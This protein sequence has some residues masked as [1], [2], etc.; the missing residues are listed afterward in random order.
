MPT[1]VYEAL[2]SVGQ[3]VKGTVDATSRDE[4]QN[5]IRAQGHYPTKLKE[6]AGAKA[7][8]RKQAGGGQSAGPRRRSVG[9]IP[10]KLLTQFTRQLSTLVDAG[11]PIVRSLDILEEQQKP[12]TMRVAIRLVKEDVTEGS[13]LSDAMK[14]HPRAFDK[15]YTNM[16]RA[17][18]L[19]GVLDVILHRLALFM[20]KSQ[21]LKRKVKGAMI[22]P[23]TVVIFAMLIVTGLLWLVVPKFQTIFK[24]MGGEL[25]VSTQALLWL[26]GWI[27]S[28][29]WLVVIGSP[30]LLFMMLKL[31]RMSETGAYGLD[32]FM[33]NIPYIGAIVSKSSVARFARTLGTL[34]T[35]GVP[36]LEAINIT[37]ETAGNLVFSKALLKVHNAIR[38]GESFAQPLRQ[39]RIVE[40]MVVNMIDVGE[41]TGE[42]DQMLNKVADTYE[43]EVEGLVEGLTSIME[44]V[45]IVTLGGIVAFIVIAL[46]MPMVTMLTTMG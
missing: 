9:K 43:G 38:E 44:P 22:Y 1:F 2:N 19:G 10:L 8:A 5:K 30:L 41:E 31:I 21:E 23:V 36:I 16:V 32:K 46:F 11:L 20:E 17:G 34:L 4:A 37:R 35:A 33:L 13:M 28:G 25:P 27:S 12:G 15:L 6:K 3:P 45:M 42:L 29:G 39:T 26:S 24:D 18:E 40:P 14:R 7:G